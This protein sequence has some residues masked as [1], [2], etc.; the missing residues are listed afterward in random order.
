MIPESRKDHGLIFGRSVI[1]NVTLARLDDAEPGRRRETARRARR[2]S[3]DPGSLRRPRARATR[4]RSARCRGATSRRCCFARMLLGEPHVLIAD[5]PTRGVDMGAKV[6]IY[7]LLVSLAESG[8]GIVLISS[9]LEE[10]LGLAHRVL[11]MRSR[12]ARRRAGRRGDDG[13]GDPRGSVRR[14]HRRGNRSLTV[15]ADPG[16]AR[17]V[18]PA[19]AARAAGSRRARSPSASGI[20]LPFTILFLVLTLTSEPFATRVN[21]LNILDQQSAILIIAAAGTLVLVAGGIDLSVGATYSFAGVVTGALRA[22]D[23]SGGRRRARHRRRRPRGR[24]QRDP[25]A[26]CCAS[27]P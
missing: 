27:T 26:R 4:R 25:R 12:T 10:I 21:L 24:G 23:G 18:F 22:E 13:V 6:A 9:E 5:E 3:D 20:L 11:V 2:R 1:E 15:D 7:E 8:M 16:R 19:A 17:R 14:S